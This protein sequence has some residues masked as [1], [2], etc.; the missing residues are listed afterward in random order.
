MTEIRKVGRPTSYTPE[1]ATEIC[2]TIACTPKGIARLCAERENWPCP[3]TIFRWRKI[4]KEFS[5][6]YA[7]S[8][9]H[10]IECLVDEILDISDDAS[11]DAIIKTDKD[12]NE[13]ET[14]NYE[15]INR[16]RLRIDTRK[17]LA[18]KL[19]PKVYG[20]KI[21]ADVKTDNDWQE[22]I[23]HVREIV[24]Q[25]MKKQKETANG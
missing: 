3:D 11:S 19:V 5:D 7:L 22:S 13:Y 25:S 12:G 20:D 4:H 18:S 8:K 2:D 14:C 17:W 6:Q 24:Q 16:A 21:Q 1:L 10:Q 23:Q 15:F 9:Q